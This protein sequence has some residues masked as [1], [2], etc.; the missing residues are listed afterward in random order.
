[1]SMNIELYTRLLS[2][3]SCCFVCVL[4]TSASV[5]QEALTMC[6]VSLSVYMP[7][8]CFVCLSFVGASVSQFEYAGAEFRRAP[9]PLAHLSMIN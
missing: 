2:V 9:R 8:M 3:F 5:R 1:M 4:S 7:V 6:R